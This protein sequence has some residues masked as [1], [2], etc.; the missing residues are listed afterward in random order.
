MKILIIY[1]RDNTEALLSAAYLIHW[2]EFSFKKEDINSTSFAVT[3]DTNLSGYISAARY[4]RIYMLGV[5]DS[6]RFITQQQDHETPISI[7][8]T[9]NRL[10]AHDAKSLGEYPNATYK[11]TT[12][13]HGVPSL[14]MGEIVTHM[15]PS[16]YTSSLEVPTNPQVARTSEAVVRNYRN[17]LVDY[18]RN[19][20]T[21]KTL[22][23][24]KHF[25]TNRDITQV[26]DF[27][28]DCVSGSIIDALDI[29]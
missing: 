15:H 10:S 5:H 8:S 4:S 20:R 28:R 3:K 1:D 2:Y 6:V 12:R 29:V 21:T 17:T 23:E 16:I 25:F 19:G 11:S 13:G 18:G 24:S 14:S 22:V 27:L 9:D 7:I 26:V